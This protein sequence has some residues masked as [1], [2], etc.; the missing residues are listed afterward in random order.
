MPKVIRFHETG[1]ADVLWPRSRSQSPYCKISCRHERR[2]YDKDG[3]RDGLCYQL[4]H[5]NGCG[6]HGM[7]HAENTVYGLLI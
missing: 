4:E 5:G 6:S 1:S 2:S 7:F 3:A